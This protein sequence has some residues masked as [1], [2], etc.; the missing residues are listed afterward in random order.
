MV[1]YERG[2]LVLDQPLVA[3]LP[4]FRGEDRRREQVTLRMLLSHS[5]GLPAY[6]RFFETVTNRDDLLSHAAQAPLQYDPGTR[7]EYSDLGFILLGEVLEKLAQKPLDVF[8]KGEV[9][10]RL[11]LVTVGFNPPHEWK[12]GIPPTEDDR[13]FRHRVLR[14][15]VNDENCW[16]LGGV[17][18]HA[19]SFGTALAIAE[20]AQCMLRG[21]AP[22]FQPGTVERF[23]RRESSPPGTSRSLGWDTPSAPSQSGKCF[24]VR[25]YGHLGYTGTSLWIDPERQLSVTLL[26]NRTWPDRSSQGIKTIRPAFH[27]AIIE[28][29]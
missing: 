25:S 2:T 10:D 7:A 17:A 8:W 18:G 12:S 29:L 13:R 4:S 22:R 21:G 20:F 27:D 5:S 6:V 26:T 23:T 1:L 9:A 19:G 3:L 14:G 28:A 16:V 24:S 15:E 11:G